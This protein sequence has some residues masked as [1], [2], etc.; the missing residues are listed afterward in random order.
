M[1]LR[2]LG[3]LGDGRDVY[4]ENQENRFADRNALGV[5]MGGDNLDNSFKVI[6]PWRNTRPF[7]CS[8]GIRLVHPAL[9]GLA[10]R[11]KAKCPTPSRCRPVFPRDVGGHA[12]TPSRLSA[13]S[14]TLSALLSALASRVSA[15]LSGQTRCFSA[16]LSRLPGHVANRKGATER[17]QAQQPR[18]DWKK[19]PGRFRETK[20]TTKQPANKTVR[21]FRQFPTIV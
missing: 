21:Q 11:W 6:H 3:W 5:R 18:N 17:G 13:L 8:P 2:G 15:R 4:I 7:S 1:P 14:P 9:S 10:W 12:P 20:R 16:H 19:I